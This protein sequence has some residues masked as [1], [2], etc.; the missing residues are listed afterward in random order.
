MK[1]PNCPEGYELY[2]IESESVLRCRKCGYEK[3]I[4]ICENCNR[5]YEDRDDVVMVDKERNKCVCRNC[6]GREDKL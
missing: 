3:K 1:C 6:L 4:H 2:V 5:V